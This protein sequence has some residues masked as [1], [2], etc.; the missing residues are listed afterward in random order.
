MIKRLLKSKLFWIIVIIAGTGTGYAIF[1]PEAKPEYTTAQVVRQE[2][3]QTVAVTGSVRGAD[4]IDLNFK[5]LGTLAELNVYSGDEV[6]TGQVL[7][8]LTSK[9]LVNAVSE[10]QAGWQSAQAALDKLMQGASLEDLAIS[11]EKVNSAEVTLTIKQQ[12]YQDLMVKLAADEQSYRDTV[13]NSQ[14]DLATARDNLIRTMENE[15]FD[16]TA[17]LNRIYAI[18]NDV[19]AQDTLGALNSF[20]E[21]VAKQSH[22]VGE[23]YVA[24]ARTAVE[25]AGLT[26]TN[27]EVELAL[28]ATYQA[29]SQVSQ[30]LTDIYT[31]LI[32]TPASTTYTQ[33]E[34]NTD[35]TNISADQATI[36]ASLAGVQTSEITWQTKQ[37]GV[38]TAE[39]NLNTFLAN[40]QANIN[41]AQGA[42]NN[43]AV[44][45]NLARAEL[46]YKQAPTRSE[47]I[48]QQRARVS[49]AYAAWQRAQADL[50]DVTLVAPLPG[51][52]TK[53]NYKLGEKIDLAKPVISLLGKSGL[54][55]EVDIP[56]SDISKIKLGQTAEI[57]LDAFGDDVVFPGQVVFIYPAETLIQDVV[58]YKVKVAFT[59]ESTE[60]KP[61][62]T[63]N[64]D[65][66]T[67]VKEAVLVVPVR[68]VKQNAQKYV[69]VL[70][71]GQEVRREV[72]TGLRGDNGLL[73]IV[74]GLN[75]GETVITFKK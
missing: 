27:H 42:I 16:A 68:A 53:V 57:T 30:A 1:K 48:N 60:I 7:A 39:N 73:E 25:Q 74:S 22:L 55:I 63:A 4:E 70:Q 15:L 12:E 29:L 67:A 10:A 19:D 61:G 52:I 44:S 71:N 9:Q 17:A 65:I 38:V 23:T 20:T 33:T 18:L 43:A 66:I 21:T 5:A 46:A 14:R 41:T 8:R 59:N 24:G 11:R 51:V 2:L 47:D 40:R 37:T 28:Q 72:V 26:K 62:M 3:V 54:E 13:V 34:I 6:E 32:N 35:K 58:Y 31:V 36:S 50:D 45:L 49:Q 56:E 75:E 64:I 69:D